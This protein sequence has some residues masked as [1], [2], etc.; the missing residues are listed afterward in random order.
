MQSSN[1]SAFQRTPSLEIS[2]WYMASLI[3]NLAEAGD[4][5]GAFCLMEAV[6]KRGNEPPPHVHSRE[7]E[8]FY[9]IEGS[10]DVYVGKEV[11]HVKARGCVF[12][13]RL[14]A[15]AFIIRSPR[16]RLLTLFSPAGIEDAFRGKSVPAEAMD[17]P[18]E[19]VT[20]STADLAET[21]RRL[22]EHGV[23]ILAPDEIASRLPLYPRGQA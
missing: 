16:I 3:T 17:L 13:P 12:L 6:L 14:I 1:L 9:V 21:T 23:R 7:D 11:F 4:T 10:F 15:H 22:S 19:A 18:A 2:K 20:Y 5:N 8:L